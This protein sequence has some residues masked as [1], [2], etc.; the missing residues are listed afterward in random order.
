MLN[1]TKKCLTPFERQYWEVKKDH[2][3]S[4]LFFKK[5]KF[6]EVYNEDAL[7]AREHFDFRITSRVRF[8]NCPNPLHYA[9][10]KDGYLVYFLL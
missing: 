3:Q 2:M 7:F 5:G 1:G 8:R 9:P 4:I 6:Y 10:L